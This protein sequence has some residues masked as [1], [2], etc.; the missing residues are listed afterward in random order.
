MRALIIILIFMPFLSFSQ[1]VN[2]T[3]FSRLG[4]LPIDIADLSFRYDG[5]DTVS[6]IEVLYFYKNDEK[7]DA[8]LFFITD[9]SLLSLE[10]GNTLSDFLS[11]AGNDY[12]YIKYANYS[13]FFGCE[14]NDV[15][16]FV[17]CRNE[18]LYSNAIDINTDS[19]F[20]YTTNLH[21]C[22]YVAKVRA[23]VYKFY[24]TDVKHSRLF[25]HFNA[26]N[27]KAQRIEKMIYKKVLSRNYIKSNSI[28]KGVPYR[29]H[30]DCISVYK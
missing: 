12:H 4:K 10:S 24:S 3:I 2:E 28:F 15:D 1:K 6:G 29:N 21:E 19:S 25:Y 30:V 7:C 20:F 17:I 8:H 26:V 14:Y 23:I 16:S 27:Y 5:V 22:F 9:T 11:M 13:S 18:P